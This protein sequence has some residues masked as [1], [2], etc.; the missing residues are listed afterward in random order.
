MK[1]GFTV[2]DYHEKFILYVF[3]ILS[4]YKYFINKIYLSQRNEARLLYQMLYSQLL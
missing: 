3:K 2:D 4:E 1:Y